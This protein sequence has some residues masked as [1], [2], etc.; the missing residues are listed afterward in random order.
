MK[1]IALKL[2]VPIAIVLLW[3]MLTVY[4]KWSAAILPPPTKVFFA[5]VD[6]FTKDSVIIDILVSIKH[7]AVGF[8]LAS[9]LGVSVGV[10]FGYSRRAKMLLGS[11]LEFL[12]PIP[13]IAW[14]PLAILWFGIGDRPAY[15]LVFLGAFFPIMSN[16]YFGVVSIEENHK[17]AALSLGANQEALLKDVVLPASLPYIFTG[18]K[19][20][21]GISWFMVIVAELVGSQSGLGYMIQLNRLLLQTDKVI[22]GMIIIGLCGYLMNRAMVYFERKL[23]PWKA[24]R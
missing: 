1:S 7:V 12:R 10:L 24:A 8:A 17:R 19:T 21:L 22:G 2:V 18:L 5:T 16:A 3:Q 4:G 15:F 9:L 14:I 13:P 11:M 20:G 23:M 6:M